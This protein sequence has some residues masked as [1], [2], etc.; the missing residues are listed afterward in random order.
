MKSLG[1]VSPGEKRRSVG[2][3]HR[4]RWSATLA[5]SQQD[6]RRF[7]P[8]APAPS[9]CCD[10]ETRD[11]ETNSRETLK[12]NHVD[13]HPVSALME[14]KYIPDD[15][16]RQD[17][18]TTHGPGTNDTRGFQTVKALAQASPNATCQGDKGS[19]KTCR[20]QAEVQYS[21]H[22]PKDL[23]SQLRRNVRHEVYPESKQKHWPIRNCID[24]G[25]QVGSVFLP[26]NGNR[27]VKAADEPRTNGCQSTR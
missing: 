2:K 14:E 15:D 11:N 22:P 1:I 10:H 19:Q 21:R 5:I 12:K 8:K 4:R 13:T 3:R 9:A 7:Y 26:Q 17:F 16:C 25:I 20:A 23:I 18:S 24:G 6:V 27:T